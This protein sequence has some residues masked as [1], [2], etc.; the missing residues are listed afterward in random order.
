MT[1]ELATVDRSAVSVVSML[2]HAKEWLATAVETTGPGS[3]VAAKTQIVMAETYA[4]ELQLSKDI[5]DDA[6]EMVR[7]AEW[8]L[9]QAIKRDRAAGLIKGQHSGGGTTVPGMRGSLPRSEADRD[10]RPSSKDY[11]T[12]GEERS[13]VFQIGQ[14]S[15][16]QLEA[17]LKDARDEGNLSRANVVRKVR[18]AS[19]K[20]A[21][22]TERN[23]Q[24]AELVNAFRSM[25]RPLLAPKNVASLSPKARDLLI[26]LLENAIETLRGN[27]Q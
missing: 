9:E 12:N 15:A 8:A 13:Q 7:R 21:P 22:V 24:E 6:R 11:F 27:D 3:I 17:A 1:A 10:D 25:V 5:Q 2:E 4:H 20:A 19:G 23:H 16:E 14:A 18:E 26:D